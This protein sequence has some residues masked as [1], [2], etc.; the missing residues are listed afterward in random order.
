MC[1]AVD[2]VHNVRCLGTCSSKTSPDPGGLVWPSSLLYLVWLQMVIG[3]SRPAKPPGRTNRSA[4]PPGRT[5][6]PFNLAE[7]AKFEKWG[8]YAAANSAQH[9][10][11]QKVRV[12]LLL[13]KF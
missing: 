2:R 12:T 9:E 7:I 4:K 3:G 8:D 10:S 11:P 1:F 6:I 5:N 13:A